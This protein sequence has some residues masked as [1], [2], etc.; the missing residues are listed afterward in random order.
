MNRKS[1]IRSFS[2]VRWVFFGST[3][4]LFVFSSVVHI[5]ATAYNPVRPCP[6]EIYRRYSR[7]E[8]FLSS[9]C[10]GYRQSS[11]NSYRCIIN[12]I[13]GCRCRGV[14]IT[15]AF[16][17]NKTVR[18]SWR[19]WIELRGE[20][21]PIDGVHRTFNYKLSALASPLPPYFPIA[22]LTPGFCFPINPRRILPTRQPF[23]SV[24]NYF[25][26]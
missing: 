17:S 23:T 9:R 15:V 1:R 18:L 16:L 4:I 21:S 19:G 13:L 22:N 3:M 26:T 20:V 11:S 14:D 12:R 2:V 10:Y 6:R 24:D 7:L 25:Y 8:F 5:V